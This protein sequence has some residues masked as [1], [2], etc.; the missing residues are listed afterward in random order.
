MERCRTNTP[1]RGERKPVTLPFTVAIRDHR[2]GL[3][4]QYLEGAT[5]EWPLF[6]ATDSSRERTVLPQ[7]TN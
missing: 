1:A 2:N 7:W 3:N 6:A 5:A 4:G